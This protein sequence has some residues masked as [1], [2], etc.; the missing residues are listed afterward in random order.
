MLNIWKGGQLLAFSGIDGATDYS[1]GLTARIS[2]EN[3]GLDIKYPAECTIQFCSG[4]PENVTVTGDSF[5][6]DT[7]TGK[8]KAVFADAYHLLVKGNCTIDNNSP[9]FTVKQKNGLTL[10]GVSRFYNERHLEADIDDVTAQRMAWINSIDLPEMPEIRRKT[11]MKALSILKT[12]VYT[13]EGR[14]K[15]RWTTPD[16]WPHKQ[17]WLW[18]SAFH[19]IGLRR[20]D[21]QLARETIEAML[22]TQEENGFI[23]LCANP[24]ENH[25]YTQPP[26]LVL[27]AAMV[28][29]TAPDNEWLRKIYPALA[30]Y[31]EWDLANRDS[32]GGG[33]VEWAI[34]NNITCRSGESGMDNS[35]RFDFATRLDAVDFNAFLS[36]E[37]ELLT[38]FAA[39]LG[40]KEETVFWQDKH[41]T[42]NNLINERLWSNVHNF[43]VDYDLDNGKQS[44][45]LASAG[46]LPL[47]CGAASQEQAKKLAAHLSNQDTFGT[48]LPVASIAR[49][50]GEYYSKDMWR[51]PVWVN[52]NWLIAYGLKRYGYTAEADKIISMTMAEQEKHYLKYGSIFEFYDDRR[53]VDPPNLL[54]KGINAPEVA[55]THQVI[56]DFGWSGTLY[57]DM[58][59][60]KSGS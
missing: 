13:P 58:A 20:V 48:P 28:D 51:G 31:I 9:E 57:I 25:F 44:E 6:F 54:R 23:P 19:A 3:T 36:H 2:F 47:I 49:S 14:I 7:P 5:S 26:V 8:V 32:D 38:G 22:D 41:N 21:I 27:A 45:V 56:F 55:P 12:Q 33:L 1:N 11:I 42:L 4:K 24:E 18:D 43:Y 35:P 16:R 60:A 29:E 17:M 10:F 53:E 30:K 52:I 50:C 59:F 15:S 34:E 46:F 39:R 40:M 37:C